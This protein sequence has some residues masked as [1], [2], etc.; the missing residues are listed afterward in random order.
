MEKRRRYTREFKRDAVSLVREQGYSC[1]QA[2]ASL[3]IREDMLRIL[4]YFL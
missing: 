3:G 1:R 2:A 4:S